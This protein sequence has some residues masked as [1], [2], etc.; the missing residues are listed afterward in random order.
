MMP[1]NIDLLGLT[2]FVPTIHLHDTPEY[3]CDR[4]ADRI[5]SSVRYWTDG[6]ME[7]STASS[8]YEPM[9]DVLG[10]LYDRLSLRISSTR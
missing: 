5:S 2:A 10:G 8:T 9:Y 7:A 4:A 3:A 6:A 1:D